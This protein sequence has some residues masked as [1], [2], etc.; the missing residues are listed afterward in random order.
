[1]IATTSKAHS[2]QLCIPT[3]TGASS[4]RS[5]RGINRVRRVRHSEY[6]CSRTS[7]GSILC[8]TAIYEQN[9][10]SK[11]PA[12]SPTTEKKGQSPFPL[13]ILTGQE[14]RPGEGRPFMS[15]QRSYRKEPAPLQCVSDSL[16]PHPSGVDI[17]PPPCPATKGWLVSKET[18]LK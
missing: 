17:T 2:E 12:H 16:S 14:T 8:Q 3:P 15:T 5:G 7:K 4:W 6:G 1:M 9:R 13:M 18:T 11:E 10:G